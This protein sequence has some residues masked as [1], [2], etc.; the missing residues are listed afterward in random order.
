MAGG[1]ADKKVNWSNVVRLYLREVAEQRQQVALR[2][3]AVIPIDRLRAKSM[4]Q[5]GAGERLDFGQPGGCRPSGFH[6]TL[7]A[8]IPEQTER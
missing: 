8:S 3:V 5:N 7:A 6:A 1:S 2:A 4:C